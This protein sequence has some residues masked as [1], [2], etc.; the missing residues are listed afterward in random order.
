MTDPN[1]FAQ[2]RL[3]HFAALGV[4]M[5]PRHLSHDANPVYALEC[6]QGAP[7][8]FVHGGLTQCAEWAPLLPHLDIDRRIVLLD[9][10]GC[11]L[12]YMI[13]YRG[14]DY[15][16]HAASFLAAVVPQLT[17]EPIDIVAN[18]MGGFFTLAFAL[19]HPHLVRSL[20]FVGAPAG[21]VRKLPMTIH[22]M[23]LPVVGPALLQGEMSPADARKRVYQGLLVR[24]ASRLTDAHIEL[25]AMANR[26]PGAAHSAHTMLRNFVGPLGCRYV[27]RDEV[28]Q[29]DL[30]VR[31][32]WGSHDLFESA[33]SGRELAEQ[34]P[35]AEFIQIDDAG[36][37]PWLD[38]PEATARAIAEFVRSKP[39]ARAA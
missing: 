25:A 6:G 22:L 29:M 16:A 14:I 30:P 4:A 27:L 11:G 37:L 20:T 33:H 19:T 7:L 15:R 38:Q 34:M 28:A 2:R 31:F 12:S 36:H 1:S 3:E 18:S 10:V 13:D 8:L 21:L 32:V 23:R 39:T 9:R 24:D 26:L 35:N 5:T 17:S